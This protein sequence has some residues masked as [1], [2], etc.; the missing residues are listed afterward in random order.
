[1]LGIVVFTQED[2][3][4]WLSRRFMVQ[5]HC[6][7]FP[8]NSELS[9]YVWKWTT[10]GPLDYLKYM[11]PAVSTRALCH[12]LK[13]VIRSKKKNQGGIHWIP[14]EEEVPGYSD[15]SIKC[16]SALEKLNGKQWFN[17]KK[18]IIHFTLSII[19][20]D[21]SKFIYPCRNFS[22]WKRSWKHT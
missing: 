12:G 21:K 19:E 16:T 18:F 7:S 20:I 9:T 4:L 1:M 8:L 14:F 22:H 2:H 10:S 11:E 6:R 17:I 3:F 15:N 5:L 13:I